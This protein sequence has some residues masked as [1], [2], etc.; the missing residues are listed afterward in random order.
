MLEK[1]GPDGWD[2]ALL[3]DIDPH[4]VEMA[5]RRAT[6]RGLAGRVRCVTGD[7][8]DA[9]GLAAIR[10]RPTLVVVSGLYELFPDNGPVLASLQ[11]LAAAVADGGYL[12]YTNQPWHPQ[13]EFI[14]RVLTSHRGGG[15]WIMR[16]RSQAE[17]DSLAAEAGFIKTDQR[18]ETQGI[19]SVALAR[20]M[21]AQSVD[22]QNADTRDA[23]AGADDKPRDSR[24]SLPA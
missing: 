18:M 21:S 16:C 12:V 14:A 8:F 22:A 2:E 1:I 3:R 9:A 13:Q 19:F 17:M 20:R 23:D 24:E 5:R 6:E 10:P 7:A 11:G 15:P 4:N